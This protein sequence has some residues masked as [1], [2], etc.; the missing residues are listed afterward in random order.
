MA[1]DELDDL[2]PTEDTPCDRAA[3]MASMKEEVLHQL[4]AA[5]PAM[6]ATVVDSG[7]LLRRGGGALRAYFCGV[8]G[9]VPTRVC[10]RP[11]FA[12]S[13]IAPRFQ[14]HRQVVHRST[15][16]CFG[17]VPRPGRCHWSAIGGQPC[18]LPQSGRAVFCTGPC[19]AKRRRVPKQVADSAEFSTILNDMLQA[20]R[21]NREWTPWARMEFLIDT[22]HRAVRAARPLGEAPAN[23]RWLVR[24]RRPDG[25]RRR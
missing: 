3:F 15:T 2:A 14:P 18:K 23:T 16:G 20:C 13:L 25:G 10:F 19:A 6:V 24:R 17:T 7:A 5:L 4:T 12:H 21:Q 9:A 11:R 8:R 22:A 1:T